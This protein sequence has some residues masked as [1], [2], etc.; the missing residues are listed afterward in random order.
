MFEIFIFHDEDI[1]RYWVKFLCTFI[2]DVYYLLF[3]DEFYDDD[4]KLS[5]T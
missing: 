4:L 2:I 1:L 5:Y 3:N